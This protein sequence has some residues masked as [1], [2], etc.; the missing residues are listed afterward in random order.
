MNSESINSSSTFS[1]SDTDTST[2]ETILN[3]S[4]CAGWEDDQILLKVW[5]NSL[6][7]RFA[8]EKIGVGKD[9]NVELSGVMVLKQIPRPAPLGIGNFDFGDEIGYLYFNLHEGWV[10]IR[11]LGINDI[12]YFL[13]LKIKMEIDFFDPEDLVN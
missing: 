4:S 10:E 13:P 1:D 12:S 7:E 8:W 11:M 3:L 2:S 5:I 9:G 6:K